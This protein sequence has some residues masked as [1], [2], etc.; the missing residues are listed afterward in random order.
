[1]QFRGKLRLITIRRLAKKETPFIERAT[2]SNME[3]TIDVA[4]CIAPDTPGGLF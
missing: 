4:H 2:F 1:M 3:L